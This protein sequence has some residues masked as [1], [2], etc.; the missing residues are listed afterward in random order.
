MSASAERPLIGNDE[1][2][3]HVQ[4]NND[5]L[6]AT[7]PPGSP[8]GQNAEI[9]PSA[10]DMSFSFR[11]APDGPDD[12]REQDGPIIRWVASQ[13]PHD[14]GSPHKPDLCT[15]HLFPRQFDDED[16]EDAQQ[17]AGSTP[18]MQ[19]SLLGDFGKDETS[20]APRRE[21]INFSV[22]RIRAQRMRRPTAK[23][24]TTSIATK[25]FAAFFVGALCI[26]S[27][28]TFGLYGAELGYKAE[29][30]VKLAT[31]SIAGLMPSWG[32]DTS[33]MAGESLNADSTDQSAVA[34]P[35]RQA[36]VPAA[37]GKKLYYDRILPSTSVGSNASLG[38]QMP[39]VAEAQPTRLTGLERHLAVPNDLLVPA[40]A[41]G[42]N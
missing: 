5:H 40:V 39:A 8:I 31:A 17:E 4:T 42:S 7:K 22:A 1:D 15:P 26:S 9:N 18:A 29:R 20:G 37:G 3:A 32:T 13:H 16:D 33:N 28:V 10:R 36:G 11:M 21:D 27:G 25:A 35:E 30:Q 23:F 14:F 41:G 19:D 6:Y 34:A 24:H 38:Q 12:V 2:N